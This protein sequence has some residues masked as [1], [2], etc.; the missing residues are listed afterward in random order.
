MKTYKTYDS[1]YRGKCPHESV[2]QKTF[3]NRIRREYPDTW[4]KIATHIENEGKRHYKQTAN[5][6]AMG[7]VKGASDIIIPGSPTFV[8]ELKRKDKTKTKLSDD[9]IKYLET[10]AQMG[11]FACVAYGVDEAW[12]AFGD[13]LKPLNQN[14]Y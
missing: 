3:F 6:N 11:A 14:K 7:M 2:E 8:C 10:C 4:G 13:Y 12:R 1:N 9:Q 5:S